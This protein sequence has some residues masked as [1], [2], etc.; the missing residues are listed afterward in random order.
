MILARDEAKTLLSIPDGAED[1]WLD[2]VLP[3]LDQTVKGHLSKNWLFDRG[4]IEK[5]EFLSGP[6]TDQ[7]V[8]RW[9]PVVDSTL[10]IWVDSGGYFGKGTD[11]FG[12]DTELTSGVDFALRLDGEDA[13]DD[14]RV[15]WSG[16]VERIGSTDFEE[17]RTANWTTG[18]G[19]IKAV[20]KA[21]FVK[22]PPDV[23]LLATRLLARLRNDVEKG[24]VV[25]SES[26]SGYSYS[27]L[28]DA[29]DPLGAEAIGDKYREIPV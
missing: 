3:M 22:V 8:L 17:D 5:T 1:A 23:K 20:Y 21:G 14:S 11:A 4:Q 7:L 12:S 18:I 9:R 13:G 6:G 10:R 27:L 16:I 24:R 25:A 26:I 15:G 28:N 19:N 2:L 29:G